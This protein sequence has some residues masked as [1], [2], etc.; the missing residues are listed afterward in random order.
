M[1]NYAAPASL[2]TLIVGLGFGLS[3]CKED[4]PPVPP[5]LSF[6]QSEMT[7]NEDAGVIEVELKLDRP[8]GKD[9]RV[10]YRIAGTAGGQQ[11][12]GTAD[13]DYEINGDPGVAII[14]SGETTGTIEV[15]IFNDNIFEEDE[16]IELTIFDVN[17]SDVQVT[18]DSKVVV[19]ITSDDAK[20]L[21]SFVTASLTVDESQGTVGILK[22]PVQLDQA[23]PS[24]T[25]LDY[26][27]GGTALDSLTGHNQK[28]SRMYYDYF[29]DGV[30]GKLTIPAGAT[31]DT[32]RL[33]IYSDFLFEDDE[34]IEI[35]L[36]ESPGAGVGSIA[37]M[38]ITVDQQDG[39]VIAL[40][41]DETYKDVDMDLFLWLG[42]DHDHLIDVAASVNP[43]PTPT[44]EL[45][46]VPDIF[47][48]AAFGLS[49][50][51]YS[52]TVEPMNFEA[53]FADFKDGVLEPE[54]GFDVYPATYTL[55]NINPW[56]ESK[57]DP[58]VVQT[59]SIVDGVYTN[60][61]DITVPASGS[62]MKSQ[63]VPDWL[64]R[65]PGH[66]TSRRFSF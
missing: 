33:N 62:R 13:A 59:F 31:S 58:L 8:Y 51:Y 37:K 22:I 42:P 18:N 63:Q 65:S 45:V 47:T 29:V 40:V 35:T 19:T 50:V 23:A 43:N 10:E 27:V 41:W 4:E 66:S 17:T 25:V 32:I 1:K 16:T 11:D 26:T 15:Q 48:D 30:F 57:V 54:A 56:Y 61:S 55:A 39:K 60:V 6:A 38:T 12:V 49:Y 34:T 36:Q 14:K 24:E 7:V 52:G 64:G 21:A 28:V 9:L 2:L 3:S 53:Q 20:L 44:V 46:F 5:K